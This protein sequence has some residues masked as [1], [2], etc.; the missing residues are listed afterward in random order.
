M[1]MVFDPQIL[2]N[3]G[4]YD[5]DGSPHPAGHAAETAEARGA[6]VPHA[7]A[8]PHLRHPRRPARPGQAGVH[9]RGRLLRQPAL[10]VFGLTTRTATGTSCTRS[11]RR[12]PGQ[13][14]RRRSGRALAVA[15]VH[16]RA[17]RV[18]RELF[19]AAHR[20][21]R[22]DPGLRAAPAR[23]A[24]ATA[25]RIGY[26]SWSRARSRSTTTAGSPIRGAS[27]AACRARA[28]RRR[29]CART[30]GSRTCPRRCDRIKV[31]AGDLLIPTPG[32]AAAGG[33]PFEARGR[34]RRVRRPSAAW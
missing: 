28:A 4:F 15:V 33:I 13:A 2:F 34:A 11:L 20:H 22:D 17:E 9:V 21:L 32:A 29:W 24:A 3:D 8:R 26:G 25:S 5:L 1:I 6:V 16:Q 7:R 18:P 19:P 31:E 27:T 30:A 23:T 12:H 14:V 10:H